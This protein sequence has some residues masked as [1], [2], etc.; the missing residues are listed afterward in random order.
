M[1]TG[2]A[3]HQPNP[4]EGPAIASVLRHQNFAL[5]IE[6][7]W[8]LA[9]GGFRRGCR[10]CT[11]TCSISFLGTSRIGLKTFTMIFKMNNPPPPPLSL[12]IFF[13][14]GWGWGVECVRVCACT[15]VCVCRVYFTYS[16]WFP[17]PVLGLTTTPFLFKFKCS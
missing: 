11:C 9:S 13:V 3:R 6:R 1:Y 10:L 14:C 17:P 2:F 5:E 4:S 15:F 12:H 8:L 16:N 7:C